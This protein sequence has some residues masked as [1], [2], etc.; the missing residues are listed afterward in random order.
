MKWFTLIIF[1]VSLSVF[2]DEGSNF[3]YEGSVGG[4][5][6]TMNRR[7]ES[8]DRWPSPENFSLVHGSL[9]TKTQLDRARIES[10]FFYRRS[11]SPL[12][13]TNNFTKELLVFPRE[14]VVRELVDLN[15]NKNESNY[16]SDLLIHRLSYEKEWDT[17][18]FELGRFFINYGLGEIFNPVNVYNLPNGLFVINDL[19]QASDG[20]RTTYFYN[21]NMD[22][23]LYTLG[24]KDYTKV[25]HPIN[26][27]AMLQATW[28]YKDWQFLATGGHDEEREKFGGEVSLRFS[29]YLGFA[30][31]MYQSESPIEQSLT[32]AMFGLDR[33]ITE[34]WHMRLEFAYQEQPKNQLIST[35]FLS[36]EYTWALAQEY[37]LHPLVKIK[38]VLTFDPETYLLYGIFKASLSLTQNFEIEAF[39][40]GNLNSDP[41]AENTRQK[42][43]TRDLGIRGQYYF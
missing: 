24:D 3:S 9:N 11:A 37:E 6:K 31:V 20:A 35:R 8:P 38:P 4:Q 32:D 22:F 34:P 14:L 26:P 10:S 40:S 21:E 2:S 28:R 30:Q 43:L 29:D 25:N 23:V 33:Q 17:V 7:D 15:K 42:L 12:F 1:L 18:R 36:Q 16:R 39:A 5:L 41:T 27:T 13:E 19:S